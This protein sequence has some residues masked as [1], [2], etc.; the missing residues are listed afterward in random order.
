MG[1]RSMLFP[2]GGCRMH[3]QTLVVS[4]GPDARS[5]R[6]ATGEVV[7]AP[8][9]WTLLPPGDATL[10]R[11][12]KAAGASWTIQHKK[13]RK[14]FSLG[15]WAPQAVIEAVRAALGAERSTEQYA[16]KRQGDVQ[17]RE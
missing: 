4:P 11:R 16:R 15:V 8:A 6:T 14:V 12:V 10:T 7:H 2:W 5:V 13:G 17:R 9:D 3:D 1:R